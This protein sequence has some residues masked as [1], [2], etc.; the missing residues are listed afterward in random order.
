MMFATVLSVKLV[1]KLMNPSQTRKNLV[2][3]HVMM[4]QLLA[5]LRK[6]LPY[7]EKDKI[8][9]ESSRPDFKQVKVGEQKKRILIGHSPKARSFAHQIHDPPFINRGSGFIR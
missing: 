3:S 6:S 9:E 5:V 7:T 2:L 8:I 4:A 1:M